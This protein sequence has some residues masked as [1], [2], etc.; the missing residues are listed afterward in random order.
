MKKKRKGEWEGARE[1][2]GEREEDGATSYLNY[3]CEFTED[4]RQ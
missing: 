1:K 2:Q 4:V 3:Q